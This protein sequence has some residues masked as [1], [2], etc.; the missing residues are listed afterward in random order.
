MTRSR[1]QDPGAWR[2]QSKLRGLVWARGSWTWQQNPVSSAVVMTP[3]MG[4]AATPSVHP[5][6][7]AGQGFLARMSENEKEIHL[8]ALTSG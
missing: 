3:P 7:R 8:K 1:G 5:L 2:D 4:K 6:A